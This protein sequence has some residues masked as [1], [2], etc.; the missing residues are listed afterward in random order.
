MKNNYNCNKDGVSI[1]CNVSYDDS[2]FN[3]TD[4]FQV[5]LYRDYSHDSI[6]FFTDCGNRAYIDLFDILDQEK[7]KKNLRG[8]FKEVM[9]EFE[10]YY[11]EEFSEFLKLKFDYSSIKLH[12][13]E[14]RKQLYCD[15]L[16]NKIYDKNDTLKKVITEGIL[17]DFLIDGLAIHESKGYSQGDFSYI[18]YFKEDCSDT[19]YFDN[20]LWDSEVLINIKIDDLE[21]NQYDY[22]L[23]DDVYSY[24]KDDLIKKV[25]AIDEVKALN[26]SVFIE[27]ELNRL[28]PEYI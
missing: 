22:N 10:Y 24:D 1:E 16:L 5:L 28:L 6:F 25:M 15:E 27:E 11:G 12:N 2:S 20:L 23:L 3:F 17:K 21:L 14:T 8:F 4:N 26:N 19:K 13:K 7:I 9:D 18:L